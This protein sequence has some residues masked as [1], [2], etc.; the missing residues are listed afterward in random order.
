MGG[1]PDE[2]DTTNSLPDPSTHHAVAANAEML[3]YV[4]IWKME[5]QEQRSKW[6]VRILCREKE[7]E[8]REETRER[9][10]C[11]LLTCMRDTL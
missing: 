10:T 3:G 6:Q 1:L 5:F 8:Q 7:R 9:L 2:N 4:G 11:L